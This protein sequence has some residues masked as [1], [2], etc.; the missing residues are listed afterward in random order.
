MKN[1]S[2]FVCLVSLACLS[3]CSATPSE[4]E[5]EY[6]VLVAPLGATSSTSS[7]RYQLRDATFEIIGVTDP[8]F[9]TE[10]LSEDFAPDAE[11]AT[12]SLPPG[13]YTVE[14]LPGWFMET[15]VTPG[16]F[17]QVAAELVSPASVFVEIEPF[18]SSS[19]NYDFVSNGDLITMDPG[20]LG[21]T[22]SVGEAVELIN[23]T[24][25]D[26]SATPR[27][28]G[29][30]CGTRFN[31]GSAPVTLNQ[32]SVLNDLSGVGSLR[33]L[34][35]NDSGALLFASDPKLFIDDDTPSW[36]DS[37]LF[38]FTLEANSVYDIAAISDVDASFY[39]D[40]SSESGNGLQTAVTNPNVAD[41]DNP[42]VTGNFGADCGV[43]LFGQL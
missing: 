26:T 24:P 19:V 7:A 22:I 38:A 40:T 9:D 31:V 13:I 1:R 28:A 29:T 39:F 3:G 42:T 15:E 10:L 23:S 27:T 16:T 8:G 35:F 14:L 25:G 41:F 43:T 5:A 32:I 11:V 18:E 33:F 36:K 2:A 34:V 37:D 4:E 30:G 6:G 20:E 21:I 12:I 17:A